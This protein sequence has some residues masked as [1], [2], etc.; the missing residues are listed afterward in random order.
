M[1]ILALEGFAAAMPTPDRPGIHSLIERYA[2]EQARANEELVPFVDEARLESIREQV[3]AL[4]A[5]AHEAASE[6]DE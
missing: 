3:L 5:L 2:D 6:E 4:A 1:A